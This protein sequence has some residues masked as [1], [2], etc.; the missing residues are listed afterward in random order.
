MPPLLRLGAAQY[1]FSPLADTK[2][3]EHKLSSWVNQ[4]VSQGARLLL[5]PE[6]AALDLVS[7]LGEF[8]ADDL[9]GQFQA[10]Q[11]LLPWY[12]ECFAQQAAQHD[13]T[14]VAGSFPVQEADGYRNR[15]FVFSQNGLI[16]FQDKLLL[17]RFERETGLMA[18]GTA[19]K[20]FDHAGIPFGICICYDAEFPLVT[21]ALANAGAQLILVPSCT[22]AATGY[23][24]VRIACQARALENQCYVVQSPTVGNAPWCDAIDT[25]YGYAGVFTPPDIGFPADG[26]I[27]EGQLYAEQWLITELDLDKVARVRS[28]G[29]VQNYLDWDRQKDFE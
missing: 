7:T 22:D 20:P 29:Q 11:P 13:I 18:P 12:L 1:A 14:I 25:N 23:H 5:F 2:A 6:Y 26:V 17:T 10:L 28:E 24:R 8:A 21:R 3:F 16:G 27:A 9:A 15:A 19:Q 4:G